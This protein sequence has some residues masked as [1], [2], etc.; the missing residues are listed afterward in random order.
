VLAAKIKA[1]TPEKIAEVEE[2]RKKEH[3]S[4]P[5]G[6]GFLMRSIKLQIEINEPLTLTPLSRGSVSDV[7]SKGDGL[8]QRY[9]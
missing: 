8:P 2:A 1:L 6:S 9:R 4:V 7:R 3:W 5:P